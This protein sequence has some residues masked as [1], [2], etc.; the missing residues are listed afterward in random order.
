M[1]AGLHEDE[2]FRTLLP[3]CRVKTLKKQHSVS[4]TRIYFCITPVK[5]TGRS[6]C[7][8][9]DSSCSIFY[10]QDARLVSVTIPKVVD[11]NRQ[12]VRA[13]MTLTT[14]CGHCE[15]EMLNNCSSNKCYRHCCDKSNQHLQASLKRT[16]RDQRTL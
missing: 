11:I 5:G 6:R 2:L 10:P 12:A 15:K 13:T 4:Q 8:N 9:D 16:S 7:L 1:V 3:A 14:K